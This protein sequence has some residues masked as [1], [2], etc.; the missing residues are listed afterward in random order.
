MLNTHSVKSEIAKFKTNKLFDVLICLLKSTVHI[1]SVLPKNPNIITIEK[2]NIRIFSSK[3]VSFMSAELKLSTSIAL[4]FEFSISSVS[5]L[6]LFAKLKLSLKKCA[7]TVFVCIAK[8][9]NL[10]FSSKKSLYSIVSKL[11]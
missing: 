6:L 7:I 8:V 1:T 2:M 9:V 11:T 4:S 10:V 3:S 5:K